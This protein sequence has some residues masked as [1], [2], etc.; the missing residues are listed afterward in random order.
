MGETPYRTKQPCG[1][2]NGHRPVEREGNAG[3]S[4]P[5]VVAARA[6]D[7]DRMVRGGARWGVGVTLLVSALLSM[8]H[9][10]SMGVV[11]TATG[12]ALAMVAV[13]ASSRLRAMIEDET[14]AS[15]GRGER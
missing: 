7:I 13:V 11:A 15:V 3:A 6:E 4:G 2:H 14:E 5:S 12:A 1:C 9:G 10:L 8:R